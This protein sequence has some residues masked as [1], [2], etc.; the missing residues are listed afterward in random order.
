MVWN[1]GKRNE[2]VVSSCEKWESTRRTW[3]IERKSKFCLKICFRN[4]AFATAKKGKKRSVRDKFCAKTRA[5]KKEKWPI[6]KRNTPIIMTVVDIFKLLSLFL[7]PEELDKRFLN[8][9]TRS[10]YYNNTTLHCSL[11]LK[12]HT[13]AKRK[14]W[15]WFQT[16]SK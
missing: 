14:L 15:W 3:S 13:V 7:L 10:E 8:Y 11:I 6:N 12:A 9:V 16:G 2:S 1:V 5:G 4:L